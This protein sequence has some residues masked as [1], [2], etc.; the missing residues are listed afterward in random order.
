MARDLKVTNKWLLDFLNNIGIDVRSHMSSLDDESVQKFRQALFVN[1]EIEVSSAVKPTVIRKRKKIVSIPQDLG[2]NIAPINNS[3]PEKLIK[4]SGRIERFRE[5]YEKLQAKNRIGQ[6]SDN[7]KKLTNLSNEL[8]EP[9]AE[10]RDQAKES[11]LDDTLSKEGLSD[12]N[13]D[14]RREVDPIE[15]KT[16]IIDGLNVCRDFFQKRGKLSLKP[17]ATILTEIMERSGNFICIFD[18]NAVYEFK[19]NSN[20]EAKCLKDLLKFD[21]YFCMSPGRSRADDHVLNRANH[22]GEP[23]I[24]NDQYKRYIKKYDWI[25]KEE[26]RL[27][28]GKVMGKHVSIFDLDIYRP[29]CTNI[30]KAVKDLIIQLS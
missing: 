21:Q 13:V 23:I 4:T 10:L 1:P 25:E 9:I 26:E 20:Y 27:I 8:K 19:R 17:L 24:S 2:E 28:K 3:E 30:K 14:N 11:E 22:T 29:V 16:F 6:S 12:K 7:S 18:A 15:G 5:K